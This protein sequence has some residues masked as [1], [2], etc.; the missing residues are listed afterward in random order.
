[1]GCTDVFCVVV[2]ALCCGLLGYI[3]NYAV[4]NGNYA[5]LFHGYDYEGHLCGV[6]T[7]GDFL[8][9]CET[10]MGLGVLD[11]TRPI[12]VEQCPQGTMDLI[13]SCPTGA[14]TGYATRKVADRYCLPDDP[15]MMAA[16]TAAIGND[17][18]FQISMKVS[19][20]PTAWPALAASAVIAVVCGYSFLV[21][22]KTL[23][24]EVMFLCFA[25]AV[26]LPGL[27]GLYLVWLVQ[28]KGGFD[29][30]PDSGNDN[31]NLYVGCG[32]L[33]F[34]AIVA[35]VGLCSMRSMDK[36]IGCIEASCSCIFS[37]PAF[38]LAP[39]IEILSK[40]ILLTGMFAGFL[41]LASCGEMVKYG[42]G[43]Y[44][45]F[46]YTDEQYL[47][48]TF[49]M[50]MMLWMS[51]FCTSVSQYVI[52]YAAQAWYFT[53]YE[54]GSKKGAPRCA[55]FAGYFKA[56]TIHMGSLLFGSFLIAFL[57]LIRMILSY[58]V[59]KSKESGNIIGQIIGKVLICIVSCFQRFLEFIN[60]SAYIE[61]AIEGTN[62]CTSA[63]AG[64]A[65][66][67]KQAGAVAI[68][69][70]STFMLQLVGIVSIAASG[71]VLTWLLVLAVPYFNETSSDGY[72]ADPVFIG[73]VAGLI[74]GIIGFAFMLVFDVV[75][76]T[77]LFCFAKESAKQADSSN[78]ASPPSVQPTASFLSCCAKPKGA[79]SQPLNEGPEYT[80]PELRSLIAQ[81]RSYT[82]GT[83]SK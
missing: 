47:F 15:S 21:L 32:L 61:M 33:G 77:M 75:A 43:L 12:C 71:G 24:R 49:Y 56:G 40:A 30:V 66:I 68:L 1:M 53:P 6:D 64:I 60:K 37:T 4:E 22:L 36:A 13:P 55:L 19:Q 29:G 44:R 3:L 83:E 67:V 54:G 17:E 25:V 46:T 48:L 81:H 9:Y 45:T 59:Q 11:T 38:L 73:C 51:E 72:V 35:L 2:L 41:L 8:F 58:I 80:P 57:R 62:F 52:A 50:F 28:F 31:A 20:L 7:P 14:V 63:K 39:V 10:G 23:A 76:D 34:A 69:S 70:G 65:T 27:C 18:F 26:G 78:D 79:V 5:R 74:C 42:G 16:A 82:A